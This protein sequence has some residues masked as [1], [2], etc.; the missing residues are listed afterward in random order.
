MDIQARYN[1]LVSQKQAILQSVAGLEAERE[2]LLVAYRAAEK[3][4]Y[5][6]V[7]EIKNI[8]DPLLFEVAL[9]IGDLSKQLPNNRKFPTMVR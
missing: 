2:Q 3:A 7:K 8:T 5:D 1:E 6:K 4:Y 9:E